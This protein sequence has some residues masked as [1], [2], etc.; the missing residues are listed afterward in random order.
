MYTNYRSSNLTKNTNNVSSTNKRTKVDDNVDRTKRIIGY[1]KNNSESN[2][3]NND[4]NINSSDNNNIINRKSSYKNSNNVTS[5]KKN[6]LNRRSSQDSDLKKKSSQENYIENKYSYKKSKDFTSPKKDS[7]LKKKSSQEN[8]IEYKYSNKKSKDFTSPKKD[9]Q[10]T[11]L[12]R[13]SSQ[14]SNLN[15][16]SSQDSNLDYKYSNKKSKDFTSPKKE[17]SEYNYRNKNSNNMNSSNK[18]NVLNK[19]S[20]QEKI[21]KIYRKNSQINTNKKIKLLIINSKNIIN[22]KDKESYKSYIENECNIDKKNKDQIDIIFLN[23]DDYQKNKEEEDFFKIYFIFFFVPKNELLK[24]TDKIFELEDDIENY[25]P[26]IQLGVISVNEIKMEIKMDSYIDLPQFP[27]SEYSEM[28]KKYEKFKERK[29]DSKYKIITYYPEFCVY[30]EKD[31]K[32]IVKI[33]YPYVFSEFSNA[34]HEDIISEQFFDDNIYIK[35]NFFNY[36][37]NIEGYKNNCLENVL[38]PNVFS[39]LEFGYFKIHFD[40]PLDTF[41]KTVYDKFDKSIDYSEF[42]KNG[43]IKIIFEGK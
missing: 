28:V 8:I 15:R 40:L 11:K 41:G 9:S 7:D 26:F 32:I 21:N 16:R 23:Y 37:V 3:S 18:N 33:F 31:N 13:R 30:K 34:N 4:N 12:N 39:S 6:N 10:D 14:D 42:H 5:P 20:S 2:K 27:F 25:N 29:K 1:N 22:K 43:M 36:L 17:N 35:S 19:Q 24:N 38:S